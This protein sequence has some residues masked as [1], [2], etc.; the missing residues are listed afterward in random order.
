MGNGVKSSFELTEDGNM[1]EVRVEADGFEEHCF[2]S[3]SHLIDEKV[4][5]LSAKIAERARQAYLEGYDDV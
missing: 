1:Y 5:A 4:K 3:S 2:V